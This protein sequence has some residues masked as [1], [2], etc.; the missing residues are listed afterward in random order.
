M[1]QNCLVK[2][3]YGVNQHSL[4]GLFSLIWLI[5]CA[6][7]PPTTITP[8]PTSLPTVPLSFTPTVVNP[9]FTSQPGFF[10]GAD[11]SY[12][13]EME[14]C[15][16]TYRVNGEAQDVF[17]LLAAQGANL[18][19]ARLWH[20]PTWT[21]YST[22]TDVEKTFRR[23]QTAGMNTLLT[24]HYSDDW[25]DPG[26]QRVPAA[27]QAISETTELAQAVYDYTREVLLTLNEAGVLPGFVQVGNETNGGLLK[28]TVGLDWPR[29][30][31]LFNAGIRAIRDVTHELGYGPHI[32]L[33][34]AQP[35]N[36][37]WWFR[38]A[39]ANGVTDFDVI[40]LSYYPQWSRLNIAQTGE[41]INALR[42]TYG[43]EVMI[44]ETAYPW[45]L[46][47]AAESAD[48]ILNQGLNLY[49]ISPQAQHDFLFDLAQTTL[50][51]GGLGIVYWEPAWVPT[52]CQ[53]RWGQGSHWENAT[54]FDF[55]NNNELLPAAA[56]LH[57]PYTYPSSQLT[58]QLEGIYG[59][60]KPLLKTQGVHSYSN[61]SSDHARCGS[62]ESPVIARNYTI[63]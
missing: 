21:A 13:N 3:C 36:T 43:K 15:G 34:V 2:N 7:H 53:T 18:V 50:N 19:R 56:F 52:P 54:F 5:S 47:A 51:N 48:N 61:R 30:A 24:I 25:A 11:L 59:K 4:W 16:A 63:K 40:G 28:N 60:N 8:L 22:L 26:Q 38:E 29:D 58:R 39:T 12:A 33:H 44:V 9:N 35:E 42:Q 20:N 23:A 62:V 57:A 6:T 27:W 1:K 32:V 37:G 45:T 14:D 46:D 55:Q 10:F 17:A 31:L 41:Q 49:G